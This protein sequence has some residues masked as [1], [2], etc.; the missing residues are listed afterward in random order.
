M[1]CGRVSPHRRST[2]VQSNLPHG[3][4]R[5][6]AIVVL[7]ALVA[8]SV[9][10]GNATGREVARE[11]RSVECQHPLTTGVEVY[12]LHRVSVSTACS[13]A[14]ALHRYELSGHLVVNCTSSNRPVLILATFHGWRLHV[15][16]EFHLTRGLASF[17]AT[18]TDFPAPCG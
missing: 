13:V 12:A 14:L 11:A 9:I 7:S 3:M 4:V 17:A 8:V 5:W 18:G 10:G 1:P 2:V 6:L 16:P 15:S